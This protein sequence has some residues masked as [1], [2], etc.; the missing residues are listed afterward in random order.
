MSQ[1]TPNLAG[2]SSSGSYDLQYIYRGAM[3]Q[4]QSMRDAGQLSSADYNIITS[5]KPN[6]VLLPVDAAKAMSSE[7]HLG[8]SRIHA[9]VDPLLQRLERF[10]EVMDKVMEFSPA[11]MGINILGIVWGSIRLMMM[12]AQD[13]SD[14]VDTVFEVLDVIRNNLPVLDVYIELFSASGIQLLKGPLVEIYK[15][16]LLFGVQAAKLFNHSVL[17][18]LAKST[19]T[20]LMKQFQHQETP[21]GP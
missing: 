6:E 8:A 20:S 15:Q 14:A 17:R 2:G 12:V 1:N 19:S 13:V 10:G 18:T 5:T 11:V 9:S 3:D 16:L 7:T 21:K 4:L